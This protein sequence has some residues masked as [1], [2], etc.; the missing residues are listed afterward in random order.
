VNR[1][2][3]DEEENVSDNSIM[4][5]GICAKSGA[6]QP[7]FIFTGK[8]SLNIDLEDPSNSLEYSELFCTPEVME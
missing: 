4:Q 2:S 3:F 8:S 5:H 6:E 1:V 7:R